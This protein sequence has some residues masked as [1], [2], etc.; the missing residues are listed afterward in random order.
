MGSFSRGWDALG[1]P[2]CLAEST[3]AL[4][5]VGIP[6]KNPALCLSCIP[7]V[8]P[9]AR[10]SQPNIPGVQPRNGAHGTHPEVSLPGSPEEKRRENSAGNAGT[11][12]AGR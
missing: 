8:C 11:A 1:D 5:S 9:A 12:R 2:S 4:A 6:E 7:S 10:R 3:E